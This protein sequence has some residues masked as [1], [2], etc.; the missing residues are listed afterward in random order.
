MMNLEGVPKGYK[1]IRIGPAKKGEKYV[2]NWGTI[3]IADRDLVD[4]VPI[5]RPI[6]PS[7]RTVRVAEFACW[8]PTL[9]E[10]VYVET[11]SAS[12]AATY[13]YSTRRISEWREIEIPEVSDE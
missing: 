1:L 8:Q 6:L 10:R 7:P 9:P 3:I 13:P 5:V 4:W 2:D 12:R 11:V